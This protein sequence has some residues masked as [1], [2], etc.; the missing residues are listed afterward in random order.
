MLTKSKK[1]F[2]S[3]ILVSNLFVFCKSKSI[4][5]NN[6][7][8]KKLVTYTNKKVTDKIFNDDKSKLL[9]L[10]YEFNKNPVINFNYLVL[11][12]KT[13][14]ELKKG[15]FAGSK[16]EWLNNN[17]LKCTPYIGMISLE[18]EKST[19]DKSK[20]NYITIKIN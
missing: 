17:T 8:D 10:E 4:N 15:V 11:D 20:A 18:D 19:G 13:N 16:I 2:I 14:E 9:I 12:S 5:E 3:L 1:M 7:D 6:L